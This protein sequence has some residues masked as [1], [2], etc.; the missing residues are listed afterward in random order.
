MPKRT[1]IESIL[2]IGAGPIVI[3]Q[4]CEF[5]Y[6]GTQA[7]KVLREEG[8]R[9]ILVNSNPATIMT[10]PDLADSTYIEPI[11]ANFIEQI[12]IKE[13]P[14]ALLATVGGQTVLNVALELFDKGVLS[15]HNVEMIGTNHTA[16]RKAEDRGL[17]REAVH[18][19][20]AKCPKSVIIRQ[21]DPIAP[22]L[23]YIGLPAIIRPSF[24]LGGIGG[25]IATT[26]A[27]FYAAVERGFVM[28][29]TSEVQVDESIIGWK[30]FEMEVMRDC[31][32]NCIVVC[33]IE[34]IDPMG[35]HTGDS[36]T[37]APA[38]TLRDE[39]YQKMRNISFDI[40]REIGVETGGS[41]VQFAVN[42]QR[43]GEIVVI[44]MNPRVS[45]SSAL[46]SKATGFPIAKIAAKLAVGYTLDEIVNDC[47]ISIPASFEPV[48]DYVVVK[49]PR[50]DFAKFRVPDQALSTSMK[51]VGEVM[52]IGRS[53]PEALQKAL[54]SLEVGYTGLNE[55]FDENT[56][57]EHVY[58][59]LANPSPGRI[60]MIADA[61]RMGVSS[62]KINEITCYDP[63]FIQQIS[64]IIACESDIKQNGLPTTKEDLLYLK[65]MGF[66]DAR[67]AELG[68]VSVDYV[69]DLRQKLSVNPVYKRIDTCAGEFRTNTAYMYGCYEGDSIN[70]PECESHVTAKEK[71]IILG[72]GP[73]RVGQGIEF[74]YTC[75]HAA[76]TVKQ[77]GLE[78]IMINCNP[79]TVS[80]DYDI[81]DRLYFSPVSRECVLDIIRNESQG[82]ASVKVIVQLGGQ[83]PLKLAKILKEKA[84]HVIGTDFESID[85]AEDRMKFKGLL[86]SL[87]LKQPR[88]ITCVTAEEVLRKVEEV[89]YPVLLRPSY[90]IGGQFMS[91]VRDRSALSSYLHINKNVFDTGCLLIDEFL[92][93]AVEV[94]VDAICD[95]DNVYIA[96]IMEHVEEAGI[97]SGDSACSL[98]YYTLGKEIVDLIAECTKKVASALNVRG[99]LNIQYAIKDKELYVL[100]VNPRASRTV[101]FIAKASGVPVA[102]IATSVM[103]GNKLSIDQEINEMPYTAVKEAVFSFSRFASADP[104]LGP[105]MKSTGEVMGI[106]ETFGMA[107]LKSQA[108]AGYELPTSGKVF[109]SVK[110]S[111]KPAAAVLAKKLIALGF[112]V[113]STKGTNNYFNEL[114]IPSTHVNKVREG[115]THIVDM[116]NNNEI[117]LVI[118]TSE[119]IKTISDS[120]DIRRTAMMKKIPHSTTLAAAKATVISLEELAAGRTPKVIP[121]REY[122]EKN[123]H[124][125]KAE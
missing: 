25:G 96:G 20:G 111:D 78:A 33:S 120:A 98:P 65:K 48:M 80:T 47:A 2:I 79:E 118:N 36:I 24:T 76:F 106:D 11:T 28:S 86:Q 50:F 1:G 49:I 85:L 31:R 115:S 84:V 74:D 27:E 109:I 101:P 63:W 9:T 88:S 19:V 83:T 62:Q 71:V 67:L 14:D 52:A 73:N 105:E 44:E 8:Y 124:R 5:D 53:L 56:C 112:E 3:G 61:I 100:E 41:N 58:K 72:S 43:D 93:D 16:I 69:E 110:N 81:S 21:G 119:G 32:D 55:V 75:V 60:L 116:L 91:V 45:R 103:L 26:E 122:H 30:E 113:L 38:L 17:F 114:N 7:C 94:D 102:K 108:A 29:P 117:S 35:V 90:V 46:A 51:S 59:E 22:A 89:G 68:N 95:G 42:P 125:R 99:L 123:R 4:A 18:K 87:G 39:E 107:F 82:A 34:N 104:L 64:R 97:H 77:L 37:V 40:L 54:C 10:D 15:E 57:I 66:S 12:I 6:S 23:E 70:T 92:N 121:V 13:K